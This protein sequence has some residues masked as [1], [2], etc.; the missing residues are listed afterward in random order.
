MRLNREKLALLKYKINE[1]IDANKLTLPRIIFMLSDL[2][3]PNNDLGQ[4][5]LN[6]VRHFGVNT[7][8]IMRSEGRLGLYLWKK[9]QAKDRPKLFT[10]E[11]IQLSQKR[12]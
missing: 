2:M 8:Y 6:T 9:A 5:A 10:T 11:K 4:N 12:R 1:L 7:S 3:L